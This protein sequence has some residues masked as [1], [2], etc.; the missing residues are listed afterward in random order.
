MDAYAPKPSRWDD[1][2]G[3]D[4]M[5]KQLL[6]EGF[7]ARIIADKLSKLFGAP[8]TRNSVIGRAA[9]K[10]F[11]VPIKTKPKAKPVPI[12]SAAAFTR[13]L[14]QTRAAGVEPLQTAPAAFLGIALIDLNQHHCRYPEGDPILFCG[15]PPVDGSPYCKKHT[16]LCFVGGKR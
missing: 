6:A 14:K 4:D 7:S 11:P 12:L 1:N 3:M 16:R 2:P 15:Q 5:L 9:R 8:L 10:K 13:T